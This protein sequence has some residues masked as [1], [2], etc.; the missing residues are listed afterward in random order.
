MAKKDNLVGAKIGDRLHRALVAAVVASDS[1]V[2]IDGIDVSDYG[3]KSDVLRSGLKK[4]LGIE[5]DDD[6]RQWEGIFERLKR[7]FPEKVEG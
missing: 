3:G 5:D 4:E 7:K 1:E 2:N 6:L